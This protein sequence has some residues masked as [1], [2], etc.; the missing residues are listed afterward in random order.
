MSLR[1]ERYSSKTF[2][3]LPRCGLGQRPAPAGAGHLQVLRHGGDAV[4]LHHQRPLLLQEAHVEVGVAADGQGLLPALVDLLVGGDLEVHPLRLHEPHG[5]GVQVDDLDP[6]HLVA[7]QAAE[8]LL[9]VLGQ[10]RRVGRE[11]DAVGLLLEDLPGQVPGPVH[12]HH[13]LARARRRPG[14]GPGR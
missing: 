2:Q 4:G 5:P 11:Q 12:G 10:V 9:D 7:A 6:L 3:T 13:R 8:V 14:H 1:A